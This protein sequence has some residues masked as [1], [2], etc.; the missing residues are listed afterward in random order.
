MSEGAAEITARRNDLSSQLVFTRNGDGNLIGG[1]VSDH[2]GDGRQEAALLKDHLG[3][4]RTGRE[5]GECLDART[6][7]RIK[8]SDKGAVF[9]FEARREVEILGGD[10]L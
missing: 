9:N 7:R 5:A 1:V 10:R 2:F 3:I 8:R 6:E 4:I